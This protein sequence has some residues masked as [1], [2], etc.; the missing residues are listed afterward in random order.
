VPVDIATL[1]DDYSINVKSAGKD[2][3]LSVKVKPYA[4]PTKKLSLPERKSNAQP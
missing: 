1:P 2:V 3:S 4:F